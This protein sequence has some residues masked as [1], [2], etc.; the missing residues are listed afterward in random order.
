MAKERLFTLRLDPA[1]YAR[2]E[3]I[4][5]REDRNVAYIVRRAIDD[6]LKREK[7]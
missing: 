1:T 6:L 4:A 2:L 7:Q 5:K 3:K